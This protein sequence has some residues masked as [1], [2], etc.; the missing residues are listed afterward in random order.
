MATRRSRRLLQKVAAGKVDLHSHL[1]T[2]GCHKGDGDGYTSSDEA[3]ESDSYRLYHEQ[4]S[5]VV[6]SIPRK[7]NNYIKV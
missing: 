6:N 2:A 1:D 3:D 4:N 5:Y 7:A